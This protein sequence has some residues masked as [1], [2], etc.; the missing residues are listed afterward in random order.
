MNL[1]QKDYN[2]HRP[3]FVSYL[4]NDW[5]KKHEGNRKLKHISIIFMLEV[6]KPNYEESI[7]EKI[8]LYKSNC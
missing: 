5:N 7:V 3:Y 6:T 2:N 1:W 8:T 4:C